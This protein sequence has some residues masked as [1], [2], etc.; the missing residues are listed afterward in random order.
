MRF[1]T[2]VVSL[3]S[4]VFLTS[5]YSKQPVKVEET[6]LGT[7]TITA[8][9]VADFP[10]HAIT[11]II[12]FKAGG[13]TDVGARVLCSV[14]Q[15]YLGQS[16]II[17]NTSGAD[18]ELGYARICNAKPD[19]YTLGFINLPTFVSLPLDRQTLYSVD[20]ITPIMN[21]VFDPAVLVVRN[22]SSFTDLEAY[23]GYAKANPFIITVGNN[24]YGASNHIAA[25]HFCKETGIQVTHVPF[26]GSVDMLTALDKGYVQS[27]VAKI[28]EVAKAQRDGKYRLLAS[29]TQ[30]RLPS[31]PD[32]PTLVEKGIPVTFGSARAL[33]APR[34]TP[35]EVLAILLAAFKQAMEDNENIVQSKALDLPLHYMGPEELATYIEEQRRYITETVPTLPL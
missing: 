27:V 7:S 21:H 1:L 29:F 15:K 11:V 2:I 4:I 18:G 8:S 33:V 10:S 14:A 13:G 5:C 3:L 26:G 24:G 16:L 17:T 23:I 32:V 22:D 31:F 9:D 25:A 30:E 19:G 28:S 35:P 34:G 6:P 12:G 20:G